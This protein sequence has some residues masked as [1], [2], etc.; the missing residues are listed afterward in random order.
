MRQLYLLGFEKAII[1]NIIPH[2]EGLHEVVLTESHG[3]L[4]SGSSDIKAPTPWPARQPQLPLRALFTSFEEQG[5]ADCCLDCGVTSADLL[6][7]F[8][9]S[10]DTLCTIVGGLH[11]PDFVEVSLQ[12][13]AHHSK[14]D[15]LVIYT[16]GSSHSA[17]QHLAPM[18][19]EEIGIPDAWCFIVLGET[20]ISDGHSDLTLIG[21]STHQVRCD[22]DSPWYLGANRIGSY[23][24]EREA[25][26]W[27]FLWRLGQNVNLPTIFRS[28]SRLA[29]D[30]AQ[31][32]IGALECDE[33]FHFFEAATR[34]WRQL[35]HLAASL[36]TMSRG[37]HKIPIQR[38]LRR[39]CQA[40]SQGGFYLPRPHLDLQ[41]WKKLIPHLWMLFGRD[42]GTPAFHGRGFC[43]NPPA[44]PP[45]Q[46]PDDAPLLPPPQP[47]TIAYTISLATANILSMGRRP[48]GC[49][50]KLNYI[51][52]QIH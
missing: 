43:V 51:R 11:L 32:S 52:S 15:R 39:H 27:A 25:L 26:A 49:A 46:S 4:A 17:R 28:D 29:L 7:F 36:L 19:I 40:R 1:L 8:S 18:L 35:F 3:N 38:V 5:R 22:P 37:I 33:S 41:R 9:S 50:G 20:Y 42:F 24:A 45:Q 12:K 31:G 10:A 44:L 48:D 2:S 6:S 13:F 30:Q 34:S 47:T 23:I 16:D 14:F 21:W